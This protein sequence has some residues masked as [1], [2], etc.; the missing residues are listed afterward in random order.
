MASDNKSNLLDAGTYACVWGIIGD[1]VY[2][3]V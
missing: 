3:Y 2:T 1:Y